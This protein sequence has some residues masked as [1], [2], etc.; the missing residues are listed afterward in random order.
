MQQ[1]R[2]YVVSDSTDFFPRQRGEPLERE[3][4]QG[5]PPARAACIAL[6]H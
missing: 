4:L 3:R 6:Q 5:T 2:T 1:R